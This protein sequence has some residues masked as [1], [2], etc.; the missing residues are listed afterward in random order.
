MELCR[1]I[2]SEISDQHV[3]YLREVDG[4]KMFPILIGEFEA[5]II[6]RRLNEPPSPRPLTHNLLK[7]AI[8]ALGGDVQDVVINGLHD[9][10]Y[11]AVLRIRRD[12][13]LVE[14]D[15]RPSDAIALSL[16]YTPPLPIYVEREVLTEAA[17]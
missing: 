15:C 8:E 5:T 16:Q 4:E 9:H 3:I 1:V 7:S 12:G 11:Y 14:V 2:L 6:T 13:E 17:Q 10:T